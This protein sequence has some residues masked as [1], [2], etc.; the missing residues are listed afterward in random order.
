[1]MTLCTVMDLLA[2]KRFAEVGDVVSQRLKAVEVSDR[3]EGW[4]RARFIELVPEDGQ[5]LAT[6]AEL[7]LAGKEIERERKVLPMP[8]S[9]NNSWK[10][11]EQG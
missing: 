6:Q 8:S 9:S 1:M 5:M 11:H 7:N 10:E 4:N 2:Q 3:D